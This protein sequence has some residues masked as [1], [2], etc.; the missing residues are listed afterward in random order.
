MK[1]SFILAFLFLAS[2]GQCQEKLW[3]DL[4]AKAEKLFQ[5]KEYPEAIEMTKKS[6]KAAEKIPNDPIPNYYVR[7]E[8]CIMNSLHLWAKIYMEQKK[9]KD[10][11]PIYERLIKLSQR[12]GIDERSKVTVYPMLAEVYFKMKEY[13]KAEELYLKT[14]AV[15]DK[16]DKMHIL[17]KN[18]LLGLAT[19][20]KETK[21]Y[22]KAEK[23]YKRIIE[24][25][26][27][28][29]IEDKYIAED[30]LSLAVVYL[31]N[32]KYKKALVQI[33]HAHSLAAGDPKIQ[34]KC[35]ILKR[36]TE[37]FLTPLNESGAKKNISK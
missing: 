16:Y 4:H 8:V 13:K 17:N 14:L 37:P 9:Y 11:I 18:F 25:D 20:Y 23:C 10:A 6:L 1:L 34:E 36:L 27:G 35:E 29:K 19:L 5:E 15:H 30:V 3:E 2:L 22:S 21:E 12:G 24:I 33:K 28:F 31:L 32:K 7:R 26:K